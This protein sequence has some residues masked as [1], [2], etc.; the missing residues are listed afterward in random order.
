MVSDVALSDT[1]RLN[2]WSLT[3]TTLPFR[4]IGASRF[5]NSNPNLAIPQPGTITSTITVSNLG[6]RVDEVTVQMALPYNHSGDLD[7][8]LVAPNGLTTTLTSG[9]GDGLSDQFDG[10]TFTDD[11]VL[12]PRGP[13]TDANYVDGVNLQ[14]AQPE[15]ALGHFHG[16]DP[17]GPWRLVVHNATTGGLGI[18][19]SWQLG[20]HTSRCEALYLPL[21]LR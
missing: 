7:I 1:G 14:Q 5:Q 3:I 21:V 19:K 2:S 18:L 4:P 16:I 11:P 20:L 10:V 9:N 12:S 13:V 8:S 17:N 6:G 15:G